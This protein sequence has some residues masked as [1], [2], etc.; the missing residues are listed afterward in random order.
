MK[1]YK[2]VYH[3]DLHLNMNIKG[4]GFR[5]NASLK[6][7]IKEIGEYIGKTLNIFNVDI[8]IINGDIAWDLD[9]IDYFLDSLRHVFKGIVV[10]TLGNHCLSQNYSLDDYINF[11]TSDY[12]PTNPLEFK[13][14]VIYGNS[15]FFDFSFR[16]TESLLDRDK[17]FGMNYVHDRYFTEKIDFN[18]LESIVPTL[19][20]QTEKQLVSDKK[21]ILVT[22][23]M[24]SKEFLEYGTEYYFNEKIRGT[25]AFKEQLRN[26]NLVNGSVKYQEFLEKQK[27]D[28]CFFG[29][30]HYRLGTKT[31][32]G[33]DYF[34]KSLGTLAE[35]TDW[36]F[37]Q[38]LYK[39][40]INSLVI[41]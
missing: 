14:T 13:D 20:E 19:I 23:Y 31:I 9:L 2:I 3:S 36:G 30:I 37:E 18:T 7:H 10:R 39:N 34:S 16:E 4:V 28:T 24:P 25:E 40:I 12:L 21:K 15:G 5:D 32:N 22:H 33:V 6:P 11:N 26:I 38:D 17:E 35:W 29:H 8:Y 1:D 41:L 27:F